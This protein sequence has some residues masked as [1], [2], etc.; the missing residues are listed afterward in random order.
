MTCLTCRS[1]CLVFCLVCCFCVVVCLSCFFGGMKQTKDTNIKQISK[2]QTTQFASF[3]Y[4]TCCYDHVYS[5]CSTARGK[6]EGQRGQ[7]R[8]VKGRTGKRRGTE[9]EGTRGDRLWDGGWTR[10]RPIPQ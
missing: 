10:G 7:R 4:A 5:L 9:A 6:G 1:L 8:E 2:K 3:C